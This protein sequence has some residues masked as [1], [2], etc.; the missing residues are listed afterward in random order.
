MRFTEYHAGVP[1]IQNRLILP[2]AMKKLAALEDA[3]DKGLLMVL[4]CSVG[5]IV[6]DIIE[7]DVAFPTVYISK[8]AVGDVSAKSVHF[9]G[10]WHSLAEEGKD[11]FFDREAA[12]K[13][14]EKRIKEREGK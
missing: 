14:V 4:P 1:V 6:Y 12:E 11:F 10:D 9:A 3:E 2:D 5:S 7:D 8:Q 13:E